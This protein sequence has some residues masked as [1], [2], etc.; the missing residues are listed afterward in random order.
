[1]KTAAALYVTLFVFA[2]YEASAATFTI[3]DHNVA[4]LKAAILK[5][6]TNNQDDRDPVGAAR[7]LRPHC[8][9]QF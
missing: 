1:M 3:G 9:G 5:A 2:R 4:A 8:A 6:N 7:H